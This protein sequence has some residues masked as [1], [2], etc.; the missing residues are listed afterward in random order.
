MIKEYRFKGISA[1]G[2]LIHGTFLANNKKEA[3]AT[4][5]TMAAK[6]QIN[7]LEII[8]RRDFI[9]IILL[10]ND[11]KIKGKQ[12]AY[13]KEE[14]ANGLKEMGFHNFI[15]KP[16]LFDFKRKP[17]IQEIQ[18][19]IK[20]ATTMLQDK[21][22]FGQILTMLSEEQSNPLFRETLFQIEKQLKIGK[23]GSEVFNR[24][25]DIF[26][27]FPAFMLGLATQ[28]GNMTEIFAATNKFIS[29]DFEI[30]KQIK[31]A[32][33]APM[34]AVFATIG[35]VLYYV[36]SIFPS[37]ASMFVK[38]GIKVPPLT[39][40]T[41]QFSDWMG[42]N[43]LYLLIAFLVPLIL[44]WRWWE[45]DKGKVWRDKFIIHLPI[46][47]TL[48]HKTSIEIFFRVFATIY[49][50][51]ANN[52]DTVKISSEACR[53]KYMEKAIKEITLPMMLV[54]GEAFVPSMEASR[55]FTKAVITRLK[56]GSETGNILESAYQIA[57][58]YEA[59]TK[60]KMDVLIE[61]IQTFI[62]LFIAIVITFLTVVS[63]EIA[64]VQPT[65]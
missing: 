54:K 14:I 8:P 25:Q 26:G 19:F 64:T 20:L 37:T 7:V 31:K 42:A 43:Y 58:Y 50:G 65:G 3:R 57:T 49:S 28:S 62:G 32:L 30:R 10:P 9:Y 60:D 40:K 55:I 17:S 33:V 39:E 63:A 38:F 1:E 41:L 29:R 48:I 12:S 15:I 61:Y 24:Y 22:N 35:A 56:T 46:I 59:E 47:G 34:F 21:M 5:K 18:I 27:K 4:V 51:S 6:Q 2:K 53:N 16:V 52:V 45:T 36:I 23:E 13:T 44:I 11:K